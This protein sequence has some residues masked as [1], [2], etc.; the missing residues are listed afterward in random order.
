MIG[1][2]GLVQNWAR[3]HKIVPKF[4]SKLRGS[5]FQS[6]DSFK[7]PKRWSYSV[8]SSSGASERDGGGR[9]D[10]PTPAPT[11]TTR[12]ST[13]TS[14]AWRPN[15]G[16]SGTTTSVF[17]IR[18]FR[19]LW[20]K[21]RDRKR[22]PEATETSWQR[23]WSRSRASSETVQDDLS[24]FV[25]RETAVAHFHQPVL[26]PDKTKRHA[27]DV[28][29]NFRRKVWSMVSTTTPDFCIV[30]F[31]ST[32]TLVTLFGE[33]KKNF[34]PEKQQNR[35]FFLRKSFFNRQ[36]ESVF[37]SVRHETEA[38]DTFFR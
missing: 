28:D 37:V 11:L 31:S 21:I 15:W 14:S 35:I 38:E 5:L 3:C 26:V 25:F 32:A 20:R 8:S 4:L 7:W 34:L 17:R 16:T 19:S 30:W 10:R 36:D 33:K 13:S 18:K 22:C 27:N 6:R 12:S 29:V 9:R 1:T 24:K 23:W 2:S